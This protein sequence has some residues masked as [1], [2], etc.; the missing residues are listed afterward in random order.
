MDELTAFE[1]R[2]AA[3]LEQLAGAG[4]RAGGGAGRGNSRAAA[5]VDPAWL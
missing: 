4:R 1:R 2:L 5:M 3:G